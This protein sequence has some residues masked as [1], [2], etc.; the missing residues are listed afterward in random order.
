MKPKKLYLLLGICLSFACQNNREQKAGEVKEP[1]RLSKLEQLMLLPRDS[2]LA[3]YDLSDDSLGAFP[4]LSGYTIHSLDVSH[5]RLDTFFAGYLPSDIRVLDLSYNQLRG[6]FS[7]KK[8]EAPFLSELNISHNQLTDV[9]LHKIRKI[10]MSYND[11]TYFDHNQS[12]TEY[13]DISNNP[14]LSNLVYFD[15]TEVDTV[16]HDNIA[17][18]KPLE[19]GP[20]KLKSGGPTWIL[21]PTDTIKDTVRLQND[22]NK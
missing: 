9:S 22:G 20:R 10:D 13:I 6:L 14:H 19:G 1:P 4:D 17:N 2:V 3:Y 5:N 8:T 16:I 18:D 15:P 21:H 12:N 7:I 11:I